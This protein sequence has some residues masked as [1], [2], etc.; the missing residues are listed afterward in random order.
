MTHRATTPR[1]ATPPPPREAD[2]GPDP[3]DVAAADRGRRRALVALVALAASVPL[4]ACA[5]PGRRTVRRRTR[6][7]VRRRARVVRRATGPALLIASVPV[8]G[9]V[10]ELEDGRDALVREVDGDRVSV[11]IDGRVETLTVEIE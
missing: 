5:G 1:D 3:A 9:E 8:A 10:L 6:R 11:E 2:D 4:Q 7:R